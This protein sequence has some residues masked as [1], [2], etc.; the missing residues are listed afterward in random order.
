MSDFLSKGY[1]LSG[2]LYKNAQDIDTKY[3]ISTTVG[4][5]TELAKQEALKLDQKLQVSQRA[6][7]LDQQL[8]IT[9]R[10]DHVA[11]SALQLGQDALKTEPGKKVTE[12]IHVA[13]DKIAQ[14]HQESLS[15]MEA[16][17][18][19]KQSSDSVHPTETGA[20]DNTQTSTLYNADATQ[21]PQ[22]TSPVP[23]PAASPPANRGAE[24]SQSPAAPA[25]VDEKAALKNA[26]Q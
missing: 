11:K 23:P 9:E 17:R 3:G 7:N 5:Y 10:L 22:Y 21:P 4:T 13:R 26:D 1:E 20:P 19:A 12:V 6:V 25:P 14:V 8:K 18:R 24:S 2:Q 15:K 16:T